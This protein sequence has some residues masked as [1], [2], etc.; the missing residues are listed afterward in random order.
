MD[1][2]AVVK[3]VVLV[4]IVLYIFLLSIKLMGISF[5]LFGTGFAEQLI[6]LTTNPFVA[7]FIGILATSIVQSS[8]VSTSIVVGL[9]AGDAL[10]IQSAVFI[11]MGANI[12]TSVTCA[13]V[14]LAHITKKREF[15]NAFEIATVHD[16]FNFILV[17]FFFPLE[18]I[19]HP[20]QNAATYFT[21]V[22]V[23]S[24]LAVQFESPL[25]YIINP[26]AVWVQHLLADNPIIIL[27]ISLG[28]IFAALR[29]FVKLMRPLAETELKHLLHKHLFSTPIRGFGVGLLLTV[30]V[31]SSSVTSSLIV[32]VVGIGLLTLEQTFPYILGANVG[33][34]FTAIM[35]SI[36]TGSPAALT[37][38][39]FHL[40]LNSIG[41]MIIWPMRRVPLAMCRWLASL[42]MH[43]KVWPIAYIVTVF[44][45]I[46]FIIVLLFN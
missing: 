34:T 14:A 3:R 41:A 46:P 11:I 37:V 44:Y 13:I 20:L 35:A 28:L 8:S 1:T 2:K 24:N 6:A 27:V 21:S 25:N 38:A 10:T 9:V 19:F 16:L 36:V 7:L 18:L 40:L 22:F 30:V 33:T 39:I 45:I 43:S 17:L 4:T 31:Q 12:G 29:S 26:V 32:P 5:K 23:G 15:R 42:S